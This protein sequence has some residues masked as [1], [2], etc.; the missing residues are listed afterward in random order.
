MAMEI[1]RPGKSSLIVES[2][3]MPAAG[4]A[5]FG[6]E[7]KSLVKLEKL[8]ALVTNPVTF[9]P[10]QPAGGTRVVPLDAGI[11][12]HTGL[13]N[14]GLS[15]VLDQYRQL[16]AG[17]P[18]PLI[19][20]LVGTTVEQVRQ[21]AERIDRENSVDAVELGLNDDITWQEVEQLVKAAITHT[22]KPVL[23]RLPLGDTYTLA[24][25]A[26]DAGAGA[27]V[28][29]APPRGTA[30]DPYTGRLVS[31]RLY[32]PLVKP[33]TLR[34][35]GQMASKVDVPII[36]AGGIHSQQDARD[37]ME[38]GAR[39]VQVDSVTWVDPKMLEWIARDLGG[40][41]LTRQAG[42]LGDE[43]FPGI[44]ITEQKAREEAARKSGD[45]ARKKN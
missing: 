22:E 33:L 31:G 7:Y 3:V 30:R 20:H 15:K 39:A 35:V 1:T 40:L 2:P 6:D 28:I 44:G 21:G 43:W 34:V 14:P 25:A 17:L 16:W 38:A 27:L 5:G 24:R 37:Y 41:V 11:L 42:A 13:P 8:G 18:M 19:L 4:T 45:T 9:Q 29:A 32:G 36:G 10:W 23:V 12:V 26:D